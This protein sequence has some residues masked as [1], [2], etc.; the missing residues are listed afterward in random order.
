MPSKYAGR[1]ARNSRKTGV[2]GH[3]ETNVEEDDK[4]S[5]SLSPYKTGKNKHLDKDTARKRGAAGERQKD[6][7]L[8]AKV[9]ADGLKKKKEK[10]EKQ[11]AKTAQKKKK[12]EAIKN[13]LEQET[14]HHHDS[15]RQ[16][17][18][19]VSLRQVNL[20]LTN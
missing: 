19:G 13:Q 1:G 17:G 6:A 20:V 5:S 9:T 2:H 12:Q 18:F 7:D 10:K 3:T 15:L 16:Q 11:K 14:N 8:K 4:K